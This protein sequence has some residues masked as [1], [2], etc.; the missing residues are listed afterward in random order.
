MLKLDRLEIS[1]FKS[2]VD[3]VTVSFAGGITAIVGPNGC[4][5]SNIS[6]AMTWVLGEQSAK[7]LRGDSM[8]DVIFNG[9]EGRKPLGMCDVTLHLDTDPSFPHAE[10]GK[11]TLGRR[12]FRSG[13]SQY[14]LNGKVVRLKEIR[15][16]LMDTGL[17]IR[18]Y[19]VIEQGKIGL[20]LSGKPQERRKLIEEAAGIT[21]YK[22]RK[23]LAEVKLEESRA[24]LLR[25]DDIVDEVDRNLRQ[26]KRQAGAARRYQ[27]KQEE[28]RELLETVL[29][30]RWRELSGRRGE[31]S[32]GLAA[33]LDL[34]AGLAA[35]VAHDEATLAA[36]REELDRL[37]AEVAARHQASAELKATIEG[38]Q[39]FSKGA[40]QR[41]QE[42]AERIL[43]GR[44][45]HER[46]SAEMVQLSLAL[47]GLDETREELDRE[48]ASAADAV[49]RDSDAMAAAEREVKAAEAKAASQRT[50][51]Q[52]L[53]AQL[54]RQKA[55]ERQLDLAL[56]RANARLHHLATGRAEQGHE[57]AQARQNLE[58]TGTR[59]T[60]LEAALEQSRAAIATV[61]AELEAILKK[62]AQATELQR[63]LELN[64]ST[65]RQRHKL[66]AELAR[67]QAERRGGLEAALAQAGL[68][69][70]TYLA[71]RAQALEGWE[72]ALDAYLGEMADAVVLAPG[73][74][75]RDVAT[76][77]LGRAAARLLTP[78]PVPTEPVVEIDDPAIVLP[79][80]QA[81]GLPPEL[82]TALPPAFLVTT[83]ADAERL[84]HAH[85]AAAFLAPGGL[86]FQGGLVTIEGPRAEPGQL[87]RE[88]ELRRLE[89]ELPR[90]EKKLAEARETLDA[91]IAERSATAQ[92]RSAREADLSK[93]Q[94]E[95][96]VARARREDALVRE[97]RLGQESEEL[98]R[99]EAVVETERSG[100][101]ER[102]A[103]IG[104]ELQ[105][106][107]ERQATLAAA[108]ARAAEELAAAQ[109]RRENL[110]ATTAD[111][112]GRLELLGERLA[113]HDRERGRVRRE[114]DESQKQVQTWESE[115]AALIRKRDELEAQ[116]VAAEAE[117]QAAL[118]G[119]VVADEATLA[120][121]AVLDHRRNDLR[122]LESEL[123]GR[124]REREA[125]RERVESLRV[126]EASLLGDAEHLAQAFQAEFARE[127]PAEVPQRLTAEPLSEPLSELERRL[128][129]TR[130][131][132]ERLGPVN[133]LAVEEHD[134]Q[135]QRLAF[136]TVQ[137][138]DIV[139]SVESLKTTIREINATS[140]ERFQETFDQVNRS[141]GE[142][143]TQLFRGGEAEMRLQEGEDVLECGIEIVAR[144]PGKRLQ[145]LMLMSGGEKA[146][147]AVALLFALF[148]TKPSPFCILDEVDAPLDDS[149]TVRFAEMLRGMSKDTQF[150]VI[151]HNKISME[152]AGSLYGVTMEER[153]VSKLV[154]V[155]LD[156]VQPVAA[157]A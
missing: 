95:L 107:T 4:G 80:G 60:E 81:L 130:E 35:A 144:P 63:S 36:G 31:L 69:E 29:L 65:S 119:R 111:R 6:D 128:A 39:E 58:A 97:R 127:L 92:R 41:L 20:I 131:T 85:R 21:R 156:D 132:L 133:L 120:A 136:L 70:P 149:N 71:D 154:A 122:T 53:Q 142:I 17:G 140:A 25:L 152:A 26:L 59:V 117:L 51:A 110:R 94:Q 3:P 99:Q 118:E 100:L 88:R 57:L 49:T 77:L 114:I 141:F 61:A 93:L 45:L 150:L 134:E 125:A 14:R 153:G 67:H 139:A 38:R 145:N 62:E 126:A 68:A 73:V 96:A 18:A 82:A 87:E 157:T 74:E 5:K 19:S 86:W 42:I 151:T 102:R 109:G 103:R 28:Y 146:L 155:E 16:L 116:R 8:E 121:Q 9:S 76:S 2:F 135:E 37:A 148:K 12:V 48:R 138:A 47:V 23:R 54:E 123:A 40:R 106:T 147:T 64:L 137:R 113:S 55:E 27:A 56:E 30:E 101:S 11:L 89:K 72:R 104:A 78:L 98:A 24:N 105:A 115:E 79:L 75:A 143:F 1:G 7:T 84:A 10:A 44:T 66:L 129:H 112:R 52:A 83:E 33:A 90:I 15:D 50:E 32:A 43:A 34:D 91:R 124:R 46:R 108:L 22:A 13:E